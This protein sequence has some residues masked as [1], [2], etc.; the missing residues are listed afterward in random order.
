MTKQI[1]IEELIP[2]IKDGYIACDK[3]GTWVWFDKRPVIDLEDGIWF[4]YKGELAYE[5]NKALN[6]APAKDWTKSLIR[7]KG[8]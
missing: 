2:F 3:D 1:K 6:I 5:L 7:I 4:G 8:E